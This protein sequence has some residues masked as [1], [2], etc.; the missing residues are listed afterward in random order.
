[1]YL[2][3]QIKEA[4]KTLSSGEIP[5]SCLVTNL[6]SSATMNAAFFPAFDDL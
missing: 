5:F 6:L 4:K 1:M 2:K 3:L